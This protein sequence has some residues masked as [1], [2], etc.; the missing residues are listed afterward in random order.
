MNGVARS[1]SLR[2]RAFALPHFCDCFIVVEQ[3]FHLRL[4]HGHNRAQSVIE[5]CHFRRRLHGGIISAWHTSTGL[6]AVR[7]RTARLYKSPSTSE[8][9]MIVT[10][11]SCPMS[12]RDGLILNAR[13][14]R[15][16]IA[17]IAR[18]KALLSAVPANSGFSSVVLTSGPTAIILPLKDG[19]NMLAIHTRPFRHTCAKIRIGSVSSESPRRSWRKGLGVFRE[20]FR[21]E[22]MPVVCLSRSAIEEYRVWL[23]GGYFDESFD[24]FEDAT[25]TIAGLVGNGFDALVLDL[26]WK[27]LLQKYNLK[28]FKASEIELGFAPVSPVSRHSR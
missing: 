1:G 16:F 24:E 13:S 10:S 21:N 26:R 19:V 20:T 5:P 2:L 22:G 15:R 11:S 9:T 12:C 8:N 7:Q 18:I 17:T 4:C 25:F 14:A 3:R 28:Y 6:F 23:A 27:D